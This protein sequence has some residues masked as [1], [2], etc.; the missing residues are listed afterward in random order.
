MGETVDK[1]GTRRHNRDHQ[2][3]N[4]ERQSYKNPKQQQ[5]VWSLK[6]SPNNQDDQDQGSSPSKDVVSVID[7]LG[8]GWGVGGGPRDGDQ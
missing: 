1:L 3:V 7:C 5:L 2:V 6:V 8:V 4:G